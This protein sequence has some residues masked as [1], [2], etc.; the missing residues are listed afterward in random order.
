MAE[1]MSTSPQNVACLQT[2]Y[3]VDFRTLLKWIAASTIV[4][5]IVFSPFYLSGSL[6]VGDIWLA[7]VMVFAF[8]FRQSRNSLVRFFR[9]GYFLLSSS[10]LVTMLIATLHAT[11][12]SYNMKYIAQFMTILWILIPLVAV[13]ISQMNSPLLF[14]EMCSW[15]YLLIFALGA[16]LH[17]GFDV[18]WILFNAGPDRFHA[19]INNHSLQMMALCLAAA[20][21]FKGRR[22]SWRYLAMLLGVVGTVILAASR[23][24]VVMIA[25]VI[26]IAGIMSLRR[27]YSL[28]LVLG[29]GGATSWLV[30]FSAMQEKVGI[31]VRT[32]FFEDEVRMASLY[33]AW[34]TL[35]QDWM[36][37]LFGV[38]WGYSGKDANLEIVVHNVLLQV[39]T[40]AGILTLVVLCWLL[41]LPLIWV[42]RLKRSH[43]IERTVVILG[44]ATVWIF[45]MFNALSCERIY[46]VGFAVLVGMAYRLRVIGRAKPKFAQ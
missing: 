36:N 30:F 17:F 23:T 37:W 22:F 11:S 10:L 7:G 12:A 21:L 25:F 5:Y 28:P 38:G 39:L 2:G 27:W 9:S 6:M 13:G 35:S 4:V 14:L 26:G 43:E 40:E 18:D 15:I 8:S 41:F 29:L 34:Q 32:E 16:M 44:C 42:R 20:S 46:W 31:A 24:G 1:A 19:R 33:A 45:W 3:K